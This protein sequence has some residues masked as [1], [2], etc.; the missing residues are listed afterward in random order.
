MSENPSR[1]YEP[2]IWT[3]LGDVS[4]TNKALYLMLW[5]K[6][7]DIGIAKWNLTEIRGLA[8]FDFHTSDLNSLG[9]R[10][11]K[12]SD[13]EVLLT[14]YLKLQWGRLSRKSPGQTNVW[15]LLHEKWGEQR[16]DFS[17][18]FLDKWKEWGILEYAPKIVEE[19]H[20]DGHKPDW[21][22]EHQAALEKVRKVSNPPAKWPDA[23]KTEVV[24]YCE[25]REALAERQRSF[26][27]C[28]EFRW[29][30]SSWRATVASINSWVA[31]KGLPSEIC[32]S[33][34]NCI[35][36]NYTSFWVPKSVKRKEY[37]ATN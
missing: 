22:L 3:E 24:S 19:Y 25:Y 16:K 36:G 14:R 29:D 31:N 23:V 12:I 26:S 8:G 21:L 6:A 1:K 5:S 20:G 33:I 2:D 4:L 10:V 37:A 28:K 35:M 17:E 18:P 11:K 30:V 34:N 15:R 13:S 32:Q 27:G 7:N 9:D